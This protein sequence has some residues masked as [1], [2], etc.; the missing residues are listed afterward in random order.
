MNW[1]PIRLPKQLHMARIIRNAHIYSHNN[2]NN[3]NAN[4]KADLS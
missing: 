3:S 4:N 1:Y 2:D